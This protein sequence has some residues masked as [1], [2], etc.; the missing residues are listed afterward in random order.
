MHVR[1]KLATSCTRDGGGD[2]GS[3][4]FDGEVGSPVDAQA[5]FGIGVN[6]IQDVF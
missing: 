5:S 3:E 4:A 6:M 2:L 1:R